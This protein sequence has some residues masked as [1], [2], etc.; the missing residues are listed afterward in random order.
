[1]VSSDVRRRMFEGG[2]IGCCLRV[3][4]RLRNRL[5]LFQT[6][7]L[8]ATIIKLKI[9]VEDKSSSD[10]C[11]CQLL[12]SNLESRAKHEFI[13]IMFCLIYLTVVGVKGGLKQ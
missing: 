6:F 2:D 13:Q 11:C 7:L 3:G 4:G 10:A 8:E 1:M 9:I 12:T 5:L